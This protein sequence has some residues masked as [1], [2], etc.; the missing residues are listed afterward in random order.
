MSDSS[1]APL[2]TRTDI[3]GAQGGPGGSLFSAHSS[4]GAASALLTVSEMGQAD[5]LTIEG[6]VPGYDLMKK[7][8][9]AI[10]RAVSERFPEGPV[11]ALCGPGN[12]GGDGYV[13]AQ[14]LKEQGRETVCVALSDP[15]RLSGDA[16]TAFEDWTGE[17]VR[18]EGDGEEAAWRATLEKASVVIDALFG[19]GLVRAVDGVALDLLRAA[20]GKRVVA[21]DMPSG[22]HGDTGAV[23]GHAMAA[24]ETVTF[25][26]AKPGHYLF[27]GAA[28]CGAITV[29][30]I[31]IETARLHEIGPQQWLNGPDFWRDR[32]KPPRATDHKYSRGCPLVVGGVTMTGAARLA[33]RAAQRSGVGAVGVAAPIDAQTV[34]KV[35]LESAIIRPYRDTAALQE[36]VEDPK[37]NAVL[38]GPGLGLVGAT[39]ERTAAA[40]RSG[41]PCVVDADGLSVFEGVAQYL[42]DAIA[43][44]C[45][46]TPHEGEFKRLFPDLTGGRLLR[47]R[48]AAARSGCVVLLKGGDT[49]IAAPDG[50]L[51]INSH[52][53]PELATAGSGDVLSGLLVGLL[54]RGLPAFEA[55]AAA[56]WIHGE[57]GRMMAARLGPS[58]I[59]EDLIEALPDAFHTVTTVE[60]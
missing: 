15:A 38:I 4:I 29:A 33:A 48:A 1:S 36:M 56:A 9:A 40:V 58:L 10:A 19:A 21:V 55:A 35:T 28:A 12:N 24:D 45:V 8:G 16:K 26:R 14:L 60:P 54:A 22:V 43:G 20:E 42:F 25:F 5:R 49:T 27:P 41:N 7:A 23:L 17:S 50:R 31:G 46:L 18:V 47:V 13:A 53:T 11:V 37:M 57:T 52:A 30:D 44:P 2:D 6:G 3:S 59:A 34:Y 32:L 39:R 51:V